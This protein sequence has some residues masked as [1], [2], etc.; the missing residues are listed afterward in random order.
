MSKSKYKYRNGQAVKVKQNLE[1]GRI[2][3][4]QSGPRYVT[5]YATYSIRT[6][7]AGKIVHISHKANGK[8]KII[9]DGRRDYFVDE[10][11]EPVTPL[12]CKSLL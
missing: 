7:F 3:Q 1:G 6:S 11:F 9:E 10:M 4:M 2:Y 5:A 12:T 8:Y